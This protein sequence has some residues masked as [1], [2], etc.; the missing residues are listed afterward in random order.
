VIL[1]RGRKFDIVRAIHRTDTVYRVTTADET[2][3]CIVVPGPKYQEFQSR[4]RSARGFS[5]P[6]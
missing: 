1:L 3:L 2:P 6:P 4:L 5:P